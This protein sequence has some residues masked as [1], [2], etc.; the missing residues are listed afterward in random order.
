[1][2]TCRSASVWVVNTI[3][4]S[5][6]VPLTPAFLG[7]S[8]ALWAGRPA[9]QADSALHSCPFVAP[10]QDPSY[11]LGAKRQ[12]AGSA[13]VGGAA[14]GGLQARREERVKL[15]E[16]GEG[17]AL[18]LERGAATG[19]CDLGVTSE[20]TFLLPLEMAEDEAGREEQ[21]T[22][23]QPGAARGAPSTPPPLSQPTP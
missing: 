18:I 16:P 22:G 8:A 5:L 14:A 19:S 6:L 15:L 9:P 11:C 20:I 17:A 7:T 2:Q 10:A 21:A 12:A 3:Q 1:M 23:L 13:V 4:T